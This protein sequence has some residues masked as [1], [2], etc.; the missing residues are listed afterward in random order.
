MKTLLAGSLCSLLLI[1]GHTHA[2]AG[3]DHGEE[4]AA[5]APVLPAAPR[6]V[7][8]SSQFELVGILEGNGLHLYLDD[9]ATNAP[10]EGASVELEMAGER[11]TATAEGEGNYHAT[12]A[13]PLD[14]GVH[15]VLTTV[16]AGNAS[17]LL[18]GELDIHTEEAMLPETPDKTATSDWAV[19][20][21]LAGLTGLFVA[22]MALTVRIDRQ[23]QRRDQA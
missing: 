8:E 2:G 20:P 11:T 10:V 23:Q 16:V 14:D 1:A 21:W 12:L 18:V 6:L 7:I 15:A 13:K 17:D 9:Y 22:I 4:K 5:A 19:A 3:H